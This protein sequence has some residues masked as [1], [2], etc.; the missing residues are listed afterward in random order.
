MNRVPPWNPPQ[1]QAPNGVLPSLVPAHWPL[2]GI[3]PRNY[4]PGYQPGNKGD[5][6]S[7]FDFL[8]MGSKNECRI[9][10]GSD[11]QEKAQITK[12]LIPTP[13]AVSIVPSSIDLQSLGLAGADEIFFYYRIDYIFD[14]QYPNYIEGSFD[15]RLVGARGFKPLSQRGVRVA[16][17]GWAFVI[18]ILGFGV[19]G[20][21]NW[22]TLGPGGT[23]LNVRFDA[24]ISPC[25]N[26][27]ENEDPA[28]LALP[29]FA[30]APG[31]LFL[32]E[33]SYSVS[34][35]SLAAGASTF[36]MIEIAGK[37]L[38]TYPT[39]SGEVPI[40]PQAV[41]ITAPIPGLYALYKLY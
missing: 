16:I 13:W 34:V 39:G 11:L 6:F 10:F 28:E 17:R 18:R 41:S 35:P 1:M 26:A 37:T 30:P 3:D 9:A 31:S 21:A 38:V 23:P 15:R 22:Q 25:V 33:F 20:G 36:S 19:A 8:S 2:N 27:K 4:Q 32:P 7:G 24:Q 29:P 12:E 5:P 40:P 14:A